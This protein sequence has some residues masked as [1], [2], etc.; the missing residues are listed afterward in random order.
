MSCAGAA[1]QGACKALRGCTWGDATAYDNS[2]L[3]YTIG[4]PQR[5]AVHNQRVG[6]V[7]GG[8][9]AAIPLSADTQAGSKLHDPPGPHPKHS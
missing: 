1:T 9:Q 3:Q 6:A 2:T 7:N 8:R 5:L 4:A